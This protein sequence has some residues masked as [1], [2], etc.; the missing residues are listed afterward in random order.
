MDSPWIPWIMFLTG[1]IFGWLLT[2]ILQRRLDDSLVGQVSE[3]QRELSA[4]NRTIRELSPQG[5][6]E[7]QPAEM[8]AGDE[9]GAPAIALACRGCAGCSRSA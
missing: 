5:T 4:A 8:I 3:L 6:E 1:L 7:A 2:W 9:A